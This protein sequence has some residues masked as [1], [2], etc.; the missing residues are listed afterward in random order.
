MRRVAMLVGNDTFPSDPELAT[1]LFPQSDVGDFGALLKDSKIGAFDR[2]ECL[3]NEPSERII[4]CLDNLFSE[5][6]QAF[7]LFY[8]SG[9]GVPG[10]G[11]GA[12][13]LAA[14][15]TKNLHLPATAV[16]YEQILSIRNHYYNNKFAVILD[17]CFAGIAGEGHKGDVRSQFQS[18]AD[19]RGLYFLGACGPTQVAKEDKTAGHGI[20]TAALIDG[21]RTGQADKDRDGVI[22]GQDLFVWCDEYARERNFH[23]PVKSEKSEL[24]GFAFGYAH[25]HVPTETILNVKEKMNW[26]FQNTWAYDVDVLDPM[27]LATLRDYYGIRGVVDM[28]LDNSL[29]F[30][31]MK[32]ADGKISLPNLMERMKLLKHEGLRKVGA[33]LTTLGEFESGAILTTQPNGE[34]VSNLTIRQK[35]ETKVE[36]RFDK[37]S[38]LDKDKDTIIFGTKD[39][40]PLLAR[41]E[42]KKEIGSTGLFD[43]ALGW[44]FLA[45]AVLMFVV[46][47]L[48]L[49]S[50]SNNVLVKLNLHPRPRLRAGRARAER[51]EGRVVRP[52]MLPHELRLQNQIVRYSPST[53]TARPRATDGR[54]R[55]IADLA[56][57]DRERLKWTGK[58]AFPLGAA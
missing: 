50:N 47:I 22:T 32:F 39:A 1:L 42:G 48:L 11:N 23:R 49:V 25:R 12:L 8:Y 40:S 43:K 44:A 16:A 6:D 5:E 58:R 21:L 15:N 24:G 20:L 14:K 30:E 4:E 37:P 41:T 27:I 45:A 35:N 57:R 52:G 26:L 34:S 56:D 29:E 3:H 33:I 2:V 51:I 46:G 55:R 17:C 18:Y 7:I 10:G 36:T 19:G 28:P 53:P 54:C 31:F 38:S 13:Y 9:H